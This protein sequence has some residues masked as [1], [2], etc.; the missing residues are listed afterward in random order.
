MIFIASNSNIVRVYPIY[1]CTFKDP[2]A[3]SFCH[4]RVMKTITR[5]ADYTMLSDEF[6][7]Y[8]YRVRSEKSG[9]C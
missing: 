1:T 7:Q 4:P 5:D 8:A 3:L 2:F 6:L 9:H